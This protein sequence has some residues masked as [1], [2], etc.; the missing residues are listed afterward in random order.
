MIDDGDW[1]FEALRAFIGAARAKRFLKRRI[2]ME[3]RFTPG[4]VVTE[5]SIV[6]DLAG[7]PW[8]INPADNTIR[9]VPCEDA[10]FVYRPATSDIVKADAE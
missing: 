9:P 1:D 5:K 8:I 2:G 4:L 10:G 7:V 3:M 6:T